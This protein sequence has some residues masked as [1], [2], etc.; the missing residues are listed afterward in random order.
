MRR[1]YFAINKFVFVFLRQLAMRHCCS[2]RPPPSRR[3]HSSKPAARCCSGQM[4][5]TDGR[6]DGQTAPLKLR[7][8]G[9]IRICLSL[10]LLLLLLLHWPWPCRA[11]REQCQKLQFS[12]NVNCEHQEMQRILTIRL[13]THTHT[14]T[15]SAVDRRYRPGGR[16]DGRTPMQWRRQDFVTG[17]KWG[18]GL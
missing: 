7:P 12:F 9:A 10:L 16:T 2:N 3:A 15:R 8:Y 6:M 11:P 4:G 17:G 13:H 5:Q 1:V 18:M 14:H